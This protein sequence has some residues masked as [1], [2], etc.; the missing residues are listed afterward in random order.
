MLS[1]LTRDHLKSVDETYFEHMRRALGFA[2][3]LVLAGLACFV[4]A[5][6]P[7]LFA[8]TGSATI[9][10]LHDKMVVNRRRQPAVQSPEQNKC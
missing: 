9:L 2:A 1:R 8:R 5:L 4:H 10:L 3:R 7:G 6:L